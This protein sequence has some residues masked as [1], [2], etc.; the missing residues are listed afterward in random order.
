[1]PEEFLDNVIQGSLVM[2]GF[3]YDPTKRA[4]N[5][6][7]LLE[8]TAHFMEGGSSLAQFNQFRAEAVALNSNVPA[9]KAPAYGVTAAPYHG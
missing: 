5:A 6:I 3:P 7:A 2:M 1:M 8:L 4:A 9:P